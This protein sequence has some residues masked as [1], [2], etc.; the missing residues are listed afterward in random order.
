[1]TDSNQ[2]EQ[3]VNVWSVESLTQRLYDF[4]DSLSD[5]KRKSYGIAWLVIAVVLMV[6]ASIP[7]DASLRWVS[8]L[9]GWPAGVILFCLGLS[10]VHTSSLKD[11]ELFRYKER[12]PPKKRVPAVI[13]GL[14]VVAVILITTS[15]FIPLGVGGTLM[16]FAALTAYNVIRRTKEE[17][18]LASQ[19]LPDPR[20]LPE[21]EE[22]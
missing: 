11:T 5:A 3:T 16:I 2:K 20:E 6:V 7:L 4:V 14:I 21:E 13:L 8:V 9:V 15:A 17:I 18:L 22:E 19:G 12:V 1:M 10:L